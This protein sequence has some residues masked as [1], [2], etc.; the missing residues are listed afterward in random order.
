MKIQCYSL[1]YGDLNQDTSLFVDN[2]CQGQY[3]QR[4]S[5]LY[6]RRCSLMRRLIQELAVLLVPFLALA[7][8]A[9]IGEDDK[10]A[11]LGASSPGPH[12]YAAGFNSDVR[13]EVS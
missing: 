3:T 2:R 11:G 5:R 13:F 10:D 4:K 1:N 7:T 6:L 12:V 8:C 9:C